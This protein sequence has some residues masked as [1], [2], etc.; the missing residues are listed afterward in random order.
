MTLQMLLMALG[1]AVGVTALVVIIMLINP[2]KVISSST[3]QG[4]KNRHRIK[5][6]YNNFAL[7]V[8]KIIKGFPP[9]NIFMTNL[10]ASLQHMY[11]LDKDESRVRA[12]SLIIEEVAI[13]VVTWFVS[14]RYFD[15]TVL[16]LITTIM[17][18]I[19]AYQKLIGDGQKFLEELEETI[20]DMVHIYNAEGRNID[21]M[22]TRLLKDRD[23]YTHPYV[24]QMYTYMRR[25]LLDVS[26]SQTIIAEYNRIVPSRHLRLIFNYIYIT[27]RYGDETDVT[28]EQLF[29]R[30]M[31]AI[32]REVHSEL[33]KMQ[34]IK[35]ET[36]GEQFFIILAVL[37]IP[38]ATWYMQEFFTFEGFEAIGRFLTSSLGYTIKVICSVFALICFFIYTRLTASNVAF[39]QY[40]EIK[41]A[42]YILTKNPWLKKVLDRLAPKEGTERRKALESKITLTEGYVGVR[43]LYLKKLACAICAT[44]VVALLLSLDTFTI[45]RGITND[46]YKGINKDTMDT[47]LALEDYPETYMQNSLTNDMLVIDILKDNQ[48]YY[49]SLT[50]IEERTEYIRKVI[51]D[52]NIDYGA[53]P[54][55]AA[56][57]IYEKFVQLDQIDTTTMILIIIATFFG[58]YMIPNLTMKLNLMLNHGAIIYDEVIGCY[59]VVILLVNHPSSNVY[60][61]LN[62]LTSFANVFKTRLQQCVDNLSER[63]IKS[64]EDG[65]DYKPFSRLIECILMAYNGADLKSAFAGIEQ[66]H[67]FQEESRRQI[68]KQIVKRRVSMSQTLSW[69]ALGCTFLLYIM[70]PM[71][72]SIVEMLTQML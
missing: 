16:A 3:A 49:F 54:E 29:N 55:I 35:Q 44:V 18:A 36:M 38:A 51:K 5:T 58:T 10:A 19:Y 46:I 39:E 32:Q 1:I 37:M 66:R 22:F 33:V 31:L 34:T 56:Q 30:N 47:I 27:A 71:L 17:I 41:W 63:E 69:G 8:Y 61:I 52:N 26:N 25:A 42:E 70:M 45:Y 60:M 59:T 28:G 11:V 14:L 15:D 48:D 65:V 12:T 24:D 50:T 68:N 57:R 20:S 7:A 64:L 53:Y 72:Y 9:T 21:M 43:P 23:S 4:Q 2:F 62:W 13:T 6:A 40:K 67:L